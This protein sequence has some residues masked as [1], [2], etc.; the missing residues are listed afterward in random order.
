MDGTGASGGAVDG[1]PFPRDSAEVNADDGFGAASVASVSSLGIATGTVA[2]ASSVVATP[3]AEAA[4]GA[5][6][7]SEPDAEAASTAST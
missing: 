5:C 7:A 4:A 6:G 1:L 3:A 2:A